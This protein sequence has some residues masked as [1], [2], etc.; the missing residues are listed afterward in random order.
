[1]LPLEVGAG[2]SFFVAGDSKGRE[3]L[4]RAKR[5]RKASP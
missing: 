1:M 4:E 5:G 2:N 3:I